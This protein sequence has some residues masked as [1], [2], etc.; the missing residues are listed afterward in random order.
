[1]FAYLC[2]NFDINQH[3]LSAPCFQTNFNS[4][5]RNKK[6]NYLDV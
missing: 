5:L 1:V 4:H 6:F 3:K 2:G